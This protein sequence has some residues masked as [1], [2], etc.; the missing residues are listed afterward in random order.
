M[1]IFA[2]NI[3]GDYFVSNYQQ[4]TNILMIILPINVTRLI[5]DRSYPQNV[6]VHLSG[7]TRKNN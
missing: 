6:N 2:N 3:E 7:V 4:K 1:I 5:Y